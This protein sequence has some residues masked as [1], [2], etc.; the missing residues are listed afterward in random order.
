MEPLIPDGVDLN[1]E[2]K[3][4]WEWQMWTPDF[5][6]AGQRRLKGA[7]VLVSRVG[8]LGS[9]VA[10]EL[11]AA[12]VG[13]LVL[14]HAGNIKH[15][16]LNRQL[17]MTH[18]ALGTSRVESCERRL[19]DLNPHIEI[20]KVPA[21]I[22]EENAQELIDQVDCVVDCAPL[23]NERFAMQKAAIA[24]GIPVVE[25][26]MYELQAQIHVTI[27]GVSPCLGCLHPED[28]PDWKREFPVFGATS[29]TVGCLAAMETIKLLSG[30][31]D[32]LA[33][34]ML[35][36]DM[37]YM[38]VRTLAVKRKTGCTLCGHL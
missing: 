18:D 5:G 19:K 37:R 12:G 29:G 20:V 23:F 32:S 16:D 36:F 7:S 24:K 21:N 30:L 15:S 22:S 34:R 35:T 38:D 2:E 4:T 10:Y 31:G 13:R 28:P 1:D 17:L 25:A 8:G 26:A 9:V 6:E 33:G 3:A 14:A 27:P 11:A